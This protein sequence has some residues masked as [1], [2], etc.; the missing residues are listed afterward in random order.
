MATGF[1]AFLG[2]KTA[3]LR[4]TYSRSASARAPDRPRWSRE[5]PVRENC[6]ADHGISVRA[7]ESARQ[8]RSRSR[9]DLWLRP[10]CCH[11]RVSAEAK[12][13]AQL[14]QIQRR[15]PQGGRHRRVVISFDSYKGMLV[16]ASVIALLVDATATVVVWSLRRGRRRRY[17]S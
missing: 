14:R 7:D 5:R 2:C 15:T 11:L 16:K 8:Q 4:V 3:G 9:S 17:A 1:S 12:G 10:R 13:Q 6:K